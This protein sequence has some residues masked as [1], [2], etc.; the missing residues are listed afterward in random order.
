M[1]YTYAYLR[2]DGTPYYI[3]K[4]SGKRAYQKTKGHIPPD[5]ERILILKENLTEEEAFKHEE[6]LIS[7][8]GRKTDGG[9]L[10]NQT[11]GGGGGI[12][13]YIMPQELREHHSKRQI[14]KKLTEE[15]KRKISK[16]LK[17][18][19][20]PPGFSERMSKLHKGKVISEEQKRKSRETQLGNKWTE[21]Q[22]QR[23]KDYYKKN[24]RSEEWKQN[25][26]DYQ[27]NKRKKA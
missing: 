8:I 3:G 16:A 20:Q 21:E 7:V 10:N 22:K 5:R 1:F 17:G 26:R 25:L 14:G 27:A 6:Y 24:P 9:I 23:L 18:R 2:E 11:D 19:K 13:G 4:G 12:S 15:H